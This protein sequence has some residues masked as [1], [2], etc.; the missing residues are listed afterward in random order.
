MRRYDTPQICVE[1]VSTRALSMLQSASISK[2][3]PRLAACLVFLT[4]RH[5]L[6]HTRIVY[7]A[8]EAYKAASKRLACVLCVRDGVYYM[9]QCLVFL[10]C[11]YAVVS[12]LVCAVGDRYASPM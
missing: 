2:T 1:K 6:I 11:V 10:C 8:K 12:V 5:V 9:S 7:T 3:P 4:A